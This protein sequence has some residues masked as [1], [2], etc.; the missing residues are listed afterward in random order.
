VGFWDKKSGKRFEVTGEKAR[1]NDN[2]FQVATIKV[3]GGRVGS[4]IDEAKLREKVKDWVGT[5]DPQIGEGVHA[6]FDDKVEIVSAALTRTEV[7]LA[8]TVEMTY[9]FR[10][11]GKIPVNWNLTVKLVREDGKNIDGDHDPLGGIYPP[12]LWRE[13]EYVVDKHMLHID[14]YKCKVGKYKIWLGFKNGSRS[15]PAVGAGEIDKDGRV[16]L[17]EVTINPKTER[18]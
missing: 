4:G 10:V 3:K 14:M 2:R 11:L 18:Q 16:L 13:G 9:V 15:I 17:G 1:V 5:E 8:G 12:K 6:I 7:K